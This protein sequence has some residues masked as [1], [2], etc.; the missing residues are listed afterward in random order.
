MVIALDVKL[1]FLIYHLVKKQILG[2]RLYA[3]SPKIARS[4]IMNHNIK[5]KNRIIQAQNSCP[6][7]HN[8]YIMI[9]HTKIHIKVNIKLDIFFSSLELVRLNNK[10]R[11][12]NT[13]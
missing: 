12:P 7:S 11:P 3:I 4:R 9:P 6:F 1:Q 13:I 5:G 8:L 2:Y 10:L